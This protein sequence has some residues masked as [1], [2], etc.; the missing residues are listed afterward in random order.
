MPNTDKID[1]LQRFLFEHTDVR[2]ELV[3][4]DQSYQD[5]LAAHDYPAAVANLLGEFLA[6][7]ALLSATL[8]FEGSITLQA[9]SQGEIPLIMAEATS[10][11]ALRAIARQAD[12]AKSCDFHT[13]L[14]D[15][16][17]TLTIEPKQGKR[18]QGI[19]SLEG[20][21]LAHC[22]ENYFQQS[23]Q[24]S[25]KLWL[26]ADGQHA[27]GMMLQELPDTGFADPSQRDN[28]WEHL[29]Q[30]ANTLT[31]SEL[32]EL[33]F[34]DLLYRLYNQESVKLFE[35]AALR[36]QCQCSRDK[37]LTALTTVG[38]QELLELIEEQG[39]ILTNC[40]FCHQHYNF[41]AQDIKQL[42]SPTI[43]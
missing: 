37:T 2:G 42:F 26:S 39:E 11:H 25:T 17:L 38:E 23:E 41:S 4:L 36:F 9:R 7:A 8:K 30:L 34:N 13:L 35:S 29:T 19:V 21:N 40:E 16:Q 10:D 1:Q 43:H 18:Y 20:D 15:G 12:Q 3:R 14:A 28:Q 6:A 27:G 31:H 22:L 24:L 32:I 5:T 33:S